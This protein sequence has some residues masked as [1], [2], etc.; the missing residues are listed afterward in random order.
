MKNTHPTT[1]A[2][3]F[4]LVGILIAIVVY[5]I[6]YQFELLPTPWNDIVLNFSFT[7][8]AGMG[9]FTATRLWMQFDKGEGPRPMWG[10][11]AVAM[12]LWAAAET[13]WAVYWLILEEVPA[14]SLADVPWVIG[15]GFF[16]FSFLKQFRLIYGVRP[17][18]EFKWIMIAVFGVLLGALVVTALMY[19][20]GGGSEQTWAETYLAV[21]YPLADLALLFAAIKL[22]RIFG[23]GLW[24]QA[25]LGL[26]VLVVSD[27]MYSILMF[28]GL[29]AQASE[30]GNPL[31]MTVDAIYFA[32]YLLIWLA[33]YAQLLL[34][35][36]GPPPAPELK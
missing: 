15:F 1:R 33:I 32:A 18:Q 29:Y 24:G 23:R 7:V 9:A 16:G 3:R 11:F 14:I 12:W 5:I 19:A 26:S 25:W 6:L 22:S 17:K 35:K 2:L 31:S 36:H 28:S 10:N 4:S 30:N 27:A 34:L 21:F 13:I 20:V 8:A